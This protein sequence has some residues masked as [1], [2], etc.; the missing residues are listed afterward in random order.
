MVIHP[1]EPKLVSVSGSRHF[2][3]EQR[4]DDASDDDSSAS[5]DSD[6]ESESLTTRK[7][8]RPHT[9]NPLSRDTSLKLWRFPSRAPPLN[10]EMTYS[11]TYTE[12]TEALYSIDPSNPQA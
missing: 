3:H 11:A 1:L 4:Q 7:S 2:N 9:L 6:S 12:T 5:S 8:I 10:V